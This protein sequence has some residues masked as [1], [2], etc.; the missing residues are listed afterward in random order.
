M[1]NIE[2]VDYLRDLTEHGRQVQSLPDVLNVLQAWRELPTRIEQ[3]E[4][5]SCAQT[6]QLRL[7]GKE[8][9]DQFFIHAGDLAMFDFAT[10]LDPVM[11]E[12]SYHDIFPE[13]VR[14]LHDSQE[15]D[16]K[17]RIQE[18]PED[19]IY[20]LDSLLSYEAPSELLSGPAGKQTAEL[21][22][23]FFTTAFQHIHKLNHL[24][25]ES[26][27]KLSKFQ[28]CV[29]DL[30]K[31]LYGQEIKDDLL[32]TFKNRAIDHSYSHKAPNL[33]EGNRGDPFPG[34]LSS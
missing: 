8:I 13:F 18:N 32:Q 11:N 1:H 24:T 19:A 34:P 22:Q 6:D 4:P 5:L 10:H 23:L 26:Y 33:I 15:I 25:E 7:A 29:K 14:H 3:E 16:L 21:F 31:S 28:E 12:F 30:Y 17:T 20:V 27:D 2:P 9:V